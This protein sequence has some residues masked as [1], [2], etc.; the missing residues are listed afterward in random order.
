MTPTPDSSSASAG[1]CLNC[2]HDDPHEYSLS[3]PGI[4]YCGFGD[5]SCGC[6]DAE[7]R[8]AR[9]AVERFVADVDALHTG[10]LKEI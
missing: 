9:S 2:G 1:R 5:G 3:E 6:T 10:A 8:S 4:D 7:M